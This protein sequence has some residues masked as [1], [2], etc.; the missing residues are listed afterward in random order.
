MS[1]MISE[2]GTAY[3]DNF[4]TLK[5]GR[6]INDFTNKS[7]GIHIRTI[8]STNYLVKRKLPWYKKVVCWFWKTDREYQR[9]HNPPPEAVGTLA[10]TMRAM[11]RDI[12]KEKQNEH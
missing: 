11:E 2:N 9:K 1:M 8:P 6:I 10:E 7:M 3:S 12:A 4:F 5:D